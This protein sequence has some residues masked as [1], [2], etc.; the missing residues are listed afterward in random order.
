MRVFS[1]FTIAFASL[2]AGAA[3][4]ADRPNLLWITSE[5][6]SP[7]LGCYGDPQAQ[8]PRLDQLANEGVRYR[9]AFA[10]SAVCS[11]ARSTLITG[12]HATSLGVQHHRSRVAIPSR[13]KLYPEHL[14]AAGYYATNN[15]KTDYNLI[16]NPQPWDASSGRAHYTNRPEGRPFFAVFNITLS[17]ESQ[18]APKEGK[19][20][21]RIAPADIVLPPYHPDTPELRRDWAN[22][23]DQMT[24][25]DRRVGELLDELESLG[26]AED[27]IVVYCS[28]HGGALPRGK[29]NLHDSGT[30]VPLIVRFPAKWRHLA[31]AAPG[32][33]VEQPVSFVDLPVTFFSLLG[34][35]IP[36]AYEGLPF[37]GAAASAPREH[38][39]LYRDRMDERYDMVRA[40]RD[41]GYRYVRNFSPH[42]PWG[43]HYTYPFSVMPGMGSWYEAY[44]VGRTTG[45]QSAYWQPKP[46]EEF[47]RLAEDPYELSNRIDSAPD[48][49]RIAA[50]RAALRAEIL[51]SRDTGFLPEGMHARLAGEDTIFD[52]ARSAA[53]PLERLLDLAERA[54]SR[55][56]RELPVLRAALAD[57]YPAIRYW[58]A[59][60][61][62]LLRERAAP[63]REALRGL[64]ADDWEDVRTAAAEAL[65]HLGDGDRALEALTGVL[66]SGRPETHLAALNTIE[67]LW[68]AG[69]A[70]LAQAQAAV[71]G[72]EFGEPGDR[73]VNFLAAQE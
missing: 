35:P 56:P 18:V 61:C 28:D 11:T 38:V 37:L 62:I 15:V 60:G 10:N 12:L 63:A 3:A 46:A 44:R 25:M 31:P 30:R 49:G 67:A 45:H 5:D 40:V 39:F 58:G 24:A 1:V 16:G 14:R 72:R 43:Q 57:S 17:H 54:T 51:A 70:T 22:Y 41:R 66:A 7:Y 21:F 50:L 59:V 19:Q 20:D 47:Y 42:R 65:G 73:I 34:V 69:A 6:N 23:Y 33:W 36:E 48:A 26:L 9:N 4:A 8:T 29:R 52:Y 2:M 68:R 53:Y 27:T 13:M 32:A 71:R 64:L 55:D